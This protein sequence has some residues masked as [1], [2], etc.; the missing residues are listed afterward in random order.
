MST[1]D[2]QDLLE[3]GMHFGHLTRRWNPKMKPFIYGVRN[4][5]HIIDL[6]KTHRFLNDALQFL[7]Q[8]VGDGKDVLF[9]GTKKQAQD[10]V[11]EESERCHMFYVNQRWLGGTLTNYRTIKASINRLKDLKKK[12]E[13]GTFE[14]LG[15][16]EKLMLDRE[17]GKLLHSLGGIQDMGKPPGVMIVVDPNLEKIAV[18]EASL[19]NIPVIALA[20]TNCDPDVINYIVPGNDDALRSIKLFLKLVSDKILEGLELCELNARKAA[21]ERKAEAEK[22]SVRE[23]EV[24]KEKTST[25][26]AAGAKDDVAEEEVGGQYSA[27]AEVAS[28]TKPEPE[29]KPEARAEENQAQTE[30]LPEAKAELDTDASSEPE[31]TKEEAS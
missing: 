31:A 7:V 23:V 24:S 15:K 29:A 18:H 21:E 17:I 1:F 8:A 28:E 16:K 20:D 9:V 19:L 5:V 13:E 25:Y 14:V 12:K 11:R 22:P 3:A 2:M 6:S 30:T 26:V 27:K 4:G 10:V